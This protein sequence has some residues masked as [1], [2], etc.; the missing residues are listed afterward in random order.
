MAH[1]RNYRK[2]LMSGSSITTKRELIR[3]KFARAELPG[4]L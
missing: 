4:K 3:G 1:L 2:I